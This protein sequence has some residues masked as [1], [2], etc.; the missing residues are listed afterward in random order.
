MEN[1]E[2][3]ELDNYK[4]KDVNQLLNEIMRKAETF[5]RWNGYLPESLRL[6]VNQY[7]D[8]RGYK[9]ELIKK[10]DYDGYYIL[11]MRVVF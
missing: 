9:P 10:I 3:L 1:K 6:N 4:Y 2:I 11:G 7:Y 5:I 8:I